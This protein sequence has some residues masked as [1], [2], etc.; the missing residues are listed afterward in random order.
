LSEEDLKR[1]EV[2]LLQGPEGLGYETPLWTLG[3]VR[4][5][6]EQEFG[7]RYHRGHVW[8]ILR[9][10]QWSCQRPEKRARERKE[11][12]I[13]HW[14]KVQWPALKKKPK[15]KAAPSF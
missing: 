7:V 13:Q 2:G 15:K 12:A 6:I 10:L 4:H 3:R 11:K 14:K 9:E 8:K 5:L 1:L